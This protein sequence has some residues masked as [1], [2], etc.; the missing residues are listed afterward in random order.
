MIARMKV[1]CPECGYRN[2]VGEMGCGFCG[3]VLER[4]PAPPEII[5]RAPRS[6]EPLLYLGI[7]LLLAPVFT[8]APVLQFM[9][10]FL[11]SLCHETG[12]CV[13]GWLA[14]CP[15]VPAISLRG[16][17]MAQ[18]GA[19]STFLCVVL[20]GVLGWFAWQLRARGAWP[21]ILGGA[22]LLYPLFAFTGLREFC[23]LLGGHMGEMAFA[24]VFLARAISGGWTHSN[25]ERAASATV[26]WYLLGS[27]LWLSWGLLFDAEVKAWYYR[28]GS[29]GLTNDYI[30][31]GRILGVD[32]GVVAFGM[33]LIALAVLPLA[34][35]AA[36]AR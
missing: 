24:G 11:G 5:V 22:A 17:A 16:H 31:V 35:L 1:A 2:G 3:R 36:R 29:F 4:A 14:G 7:G 6:R 12:H 19:Q 27:N 26:G 32:L 13:L 25:A 23:F 21:W 15:S 10:W 30:R 18:H 9:G 8:F 34:W 33:L 20:W 28:S